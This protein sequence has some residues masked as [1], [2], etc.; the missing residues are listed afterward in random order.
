MRQLMFLGLIVAFISPVFGGELKKVDQLIR[1]TV[2]RVMT[3]VRNN[4]LNADEKAEKIMGVVTLVFDLPLMAKLTLGKKNW[5]KFSMKQREIFTSL[6]MKQLRETYMGNVEMVADE[7]VVFDDPFYKSK[8]VHMMTR[9]ITKEN[10][11][12]I[13]YK[14]YFKKKTKKWRVYD[15][16]IQGISIVKSYGM[17]YDQVLQNETVETLLQKME[18]RTEQNK[19]KNVSPEIEDHSP[20]QQ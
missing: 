12:D 3:V 10:P 5:P 4:E 16:E 20:Q 18:E 2:D 14:L 6:F 1:K 7:E 15:V 8:K 9:V 17:Q 13:F 11:I 19:R